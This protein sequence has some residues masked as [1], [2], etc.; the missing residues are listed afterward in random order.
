[1]RYSISEDP[2]QSA[3]FSPGILAL[4]AE[5][6]TRDE[7]IIFYR[8]IKQICENCLEQFIR[9]ATRPTDLPYLIMR[10][11]L[12]ESLMILWRRTGDVQYRR[13]GLKMAETIEQEWRVTG[14]Y[15]FPGT[16]I[17]PA[18]LLAE[19]FKFLYLLFAPSS[20]LSLDDYVFNT[21]GH[22]YRINKENPKE[23]PENIVV[24]LSNPDAK[25]RRQVRVIQALRPFPEDDL[26]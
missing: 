22:P 12:A 17:Q 23:G 16:D 11:R 7:R 13:M 18:F 25:P 19:T 1:M 21:A 15:R 4:A 10:P 24:W 8:S 2:D 6:T 3:C 20:I 9:T 14:G 5:P 26:Q